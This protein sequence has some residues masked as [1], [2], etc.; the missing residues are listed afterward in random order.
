MV[1]TPATAIVMLPL[2]VCAVVFCGITIALDNPTTAWRWY[3]GNVVAVR[4]SMS[5][6]YRRRV[7][8]TKKIAI[9]YRTQFRLAFRYIID[10]RVT[11]MC[12]VFGLMGMIAF[13]MFPLVSVIVISVVFLTTS[14]VVSVTN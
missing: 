12:T 13:Q 11:I 6:F 3:V 9:F 2:L 10:S 8:R 1:L 14:L 7:V 5:G 4:D